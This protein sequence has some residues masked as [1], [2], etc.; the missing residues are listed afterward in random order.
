[1]RLAAGTRLGIYEV[2]GP[3]GSGGMG[4]VY[5]ARDTKLGREV[6]LKII[7]E[8]FTEDPERMARFEREAKMLAA[9]NHPNIAAIYGVEESTGA[10]A[11]VMELVGGATLAERLRKGRM[12]LEEVLPVARQI[13]EGLEAAHEKGIIHRDLKPANIKITHDG[14]VKVLDFGLAKPELSET[15]G[16]D[17]DNSPTIRQM[18][19][20]AGQVLG[21][22]A[23]MSPEQARGKPLDKRTDIWSFGCVLFEMVTGKRAYEG[24]TVTDVLACVIRGEPDWNLLGPETQPGLRKLLRRCLEKDQ[25][26]RLRDIGDARIALDEVARA[27]AS[28]ETASSSQ[29]V[30]EGRP[31]AKGRRTMALAAAAMVIAVGVM[32]WMKPK[33]EL[34]PVRKLEIPVAHLDLGGAE[35]FEIS[36]QGK[37]IAYVSNRRV[38]IRQLDHLDSQE[39]AGSEGALELFWSPDG[40]MIGF[41]TP[42]KVWK[43]PVG[44]GPATAIANLPGWT[45]NGGAAWSPNGVIYLTP[46]FTGLLKVNDG[47]GAL[48]T[49]LPV[50]PNTEFDFHQVSTLP[51]NRG[52]IFVVHGKKPP[53]DALQVWSEGQRKVVLELPGERLGTPVYS[54][55]G[56]ILFSRQGASPGLW[57]A[58]FSLKS[59]ETTGQPFL[60]EADASYPS[61]AADGTLAVLHGARVPKT[62]MVWLDRQGQ[63]T[64]TIG[65]PD[66]QYPFP[67][68]SPDGTKVAIVA[69]REGKPDLWVQDVQR[70]TRTRA[71]YSGISTEFE[72]SWSPGGDRI[73]AEIGYDPASAQIEA[74]QTDGS[75]KPQVLVRGVKGSFSPDGKL[76]TYCVWGDQSNWDLWYVELTPGAKPAPYL[77]TPAAE[78][79]L[80]LSPDMRYAAYVSNE[81][82][83]NE[84][85]VKPFP[86]G[87]G[88]WQVSLNG[89]YWPHWNRAGN[90][91]FFVQGDD[92]MAAQVRARPEFAPGT[93]QKLFTHPESG[94]AL[95]E[96]SPDDFDISLDGRHFLFL[97]NASKGAA[98]QGILIVQNWYAQFANSQR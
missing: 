14:T 50:D 93:P 79:A 91:L 47:G 84:I 53:Q 23:Y 11:L 42:T 58:P 1:M 61:V 43:V 30:Y 81:S 69:V 85:Y 27:E 9:L 73:T 76:L 55:P 90:E 54:A 89:G 88:K 40:T 52:V 65:A 33:P 87:P 8:E 32:L 62:Q 2:V 13:A 75:G 70:G 16:M 29:V 3:L 86:S 57:A 36:P 4:E 31:K 60:V 64:G 71:S 96:G 21:T 41:V 83:R 12:P 72:P 74:V 49:V 56:V 15:S 45:Q 6:A 97:E 22:A 80:E 37:R 24:E 92:L 59:L 78:Y 67:A 17:L 39:V 68:L 18:A 26:N 35:P 7:S 63:T 98:P 82:G 44:G 46:G 34:G 19:T 28:G 66:E 48:T 10:P 51:E 94:V 20:R 38:W 5:R 77:Q 25:K 95:S